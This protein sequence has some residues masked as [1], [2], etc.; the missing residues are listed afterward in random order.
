MLLYKFVPTVGI[1]NQVAFGVFR[2]YELVK[3]I[4][5]EEDDVGRSDA[6]EG[7]VSFPDDKTLAFI[8]KLPTG[9]FKG[10]EFQCQSI[11][12]PDEHLR[13]YFVFCM[14]TVKTERA[15]GDCK[16]AVELNRD[17]FEMFEKFLHE[18][19][20]FDPCVGER[21]FSH[22]AIEY[23]D[24]DHHPEPFGGNNWREVYVKHSIF[25]HQEEYRAALFVSDVFFDRTSKTPMVVER[26]IKGPNGDALPF[27]LKFLLR[28]GVDQAGWR[29]VEIDASEFQAKLS[30]EPS[31]IIVFGD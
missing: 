8:Q 28:S 20:G 13:Q 3:Y 4:K 7:S 21:I 17:C 23:Y 22:G 6:M 19:Y 12:L 2:F 29:Y 14:S 18:H 15:I 10:I 11:R 5:I 16:F 25:S 27:N 24:I 9:S 26:Q 30:H 1:A 31:K